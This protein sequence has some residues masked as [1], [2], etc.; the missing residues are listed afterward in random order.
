MGIDIKN[1]PY[2]LGID[3]GTSNSAIAVYTKGESV[4]LP[5]DG[6]KSC[7]SVMNVKEN[8]EILVGRQAKRK[9]LIDPE[10]TVGSIK[11]E[12]GNP[13][14]IKEFKGLPDKKYAPAD[15]SA[16]ILS[17]LKEGARQAGTVDLKGTPRFA[18]ICIPAN[19]TDAQ[20]TATMEAGKLANLE[21]LY[22][23]EEPVA[24]SI[25]YAKEKERDQTIL[26][27]DL[28][29]GTFDVSILKVQSAESGKA[30]FKVLAKEGVPRLGGD[31]FDQ[32]IIELTAKKVEELSGINVLDLVKDYGVSKKL[33]R[34]A[35]QKLKEAAE[36]AKM[37]L[38]E[39][40]N[41]QITVPYII[42]DEAG[43]T[44]DLDM[45]LTRGQ[46]EDI[47]RDLIFQSKDAVQRAMDSSKISIDDV[48]RIILVG[49]STKIPLIKSMLKEMFNKEPYSDMDPDT[50]V[51]RGA[52]IF[53]STL[54]LPD[55]EL[56]S[57]KKED[58]NDDEMILE[59]K[60][61]HF[62]GIEITGGK[63][64]C[65]IEKD[66]DIPKDAPLVASKEYTTPRDN[67]SEMS[68]RIYQSERKVEYVGAEG[69]TCIGEF[70][71]TG[72]PPKP[73]RQEC[74][75]VTFE[76]N[77]QNLLKVKAT[78]SGSTGELEISKSKK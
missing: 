39:A 60:V 72:I 69:V 9:M 70:S 16:E 8:G 71:I 21:V 67:M 33:L 31:D 74:V 52:A 66:V 36:T 19:F 45:E 63:F 75:A 77:Q 42:K 58:Q 11:R 7:P 48:S 57:E 38:T 51:A 13:S 28:G 32:K 73:A 59:Q 64:N 29:G 15:I 14:W 76:I 3:L 24:A 18:V 53:G 46:F 43:K 50:A 34:E 49:G 47:V 30:E 35:Q 25:A 22:L 26:V 27:Y 44:Y 37:E 23:L 2:V 65:L 40:E 54:I 10:N 55:D 78:S 41:S 61:T 68:I 20:K 4:I 62:L 1:S 56:D 5:I 12:M 6:E 17:K